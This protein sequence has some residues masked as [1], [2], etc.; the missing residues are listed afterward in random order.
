[1]IFELLHFKSKR[2]TNCSISE[3]YSSMAVVAERIKKSGPGKD[4]LAYYS[5]AC[6]HL[7]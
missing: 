7:Q 4:T 5:H 3:I 2:I 6:A 1:M